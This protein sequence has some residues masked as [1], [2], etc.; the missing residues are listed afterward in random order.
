MP[1]FACSAI[2]IA[3]RSFHVIRCRGCSFSCK[4]AYWG[5][6]G[7]PKWQLVQSLSPPR[8]GRKLNYA[9][10]HSQKFENN[11]AFHSHSTGQAK[12]RS[13]IL[14][15]AL[16]WPIIFPKLGRWRPLFSFQPRDVLRLDVA[17]PVGVADRSMS[18][19]LYRAHKPP[20]DATKTWHCEDSQPKLVDSDLHMILEEGKNRRFCRQT[21][22]NLFNIVQLIAS[23]ERNTLPSHVCLYRCSWPWQR[24]LPMLGRG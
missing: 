17:P 18:N 13:K 21:S 16:M 23:V 11:L 2:V 7:M 15:N 4:P 19:E 8:P 10:E 20:V 6:N 24:L 22:C 9:V 1:N 12:A 3:H 5:F 14:D